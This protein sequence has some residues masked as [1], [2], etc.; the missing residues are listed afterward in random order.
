MLAEGWRSRICSAR[1]TYL[2]MRQFGADLPLPG[3]IPTSSDVVGSIP[4]SRSLAEIRAFIGER[5]RSQ[6]AVL[7]GEQLAQAEL[8]EA[9]HCG[10]FGEELAAAG[11][12]DARP[13]VAGAAAMGEGGR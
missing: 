3:C 6:C 9:L 13:P 5:W 1:S 4:A 10:M 12:P 11:D 8:T 2:P 7:W